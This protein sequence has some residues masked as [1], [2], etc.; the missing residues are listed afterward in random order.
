[1][2]TKIIPD[3]IMDNGYGILVP[4]T[5]DK[6][7]WNRAM[8]DIAKNNTWCPDISRIIFNVGERVL[9]SHVDEKTGKKIVDKTAP[10]LTT[11]MEFNDNT[12]VVVSNSEHDPITLVKDPET[13]VMTASE[14]DKEIGVAYATLKKL[15][16]VPDEKGMVIGKGFGRI[17][18]E[19]V[20]MGYDT[21]VQTR[22]NDMKKAEAKARALLAKKNAK[23]KQPRESLAHAVDRLSEALD[24][25]NAPAKASACES[26]SDDTKTS[27]A[28]S[29]K[30]KKSWCQKPAVPRKRNA[31]GQFV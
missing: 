8:T 11:V 1:M 9:E 4:T 25:M 23:P 14:R 28:K 5:V 20:N 13:G 12:K 22:K 10:M 31:K 21:A 7:L 3:R 24:K 2:T 30:A 18:K 19:I 17:L 6:T 29:M 26:K 15:I 27:K 16:G